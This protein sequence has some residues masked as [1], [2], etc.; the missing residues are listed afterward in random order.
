M[1]SCDGCHSKFNRQGDLIQHLQKSKNLLCAAARESLQ[2][3]MRPVQGGRPLSPTR[4]PRKHR[5]TTPLAAGPSSEGAEERL[6][7][8]QFEGDFFGNDYGDADFPF[9]EDGVP[10]GSDE[11]DVED[12][13]VYWDSEGEDG[14]FSTANQPQ[15]SGRSTTGVRDHQQPQD[16]RAPSVPPVAGSAEPPADSMDVDEDNR[17][18]DRRSLAPGGVSVEGH[19]RLKKAPVYVSKFGGQAGKPLTASSI[20]GVAGYSGY[21]EQTGGHENIWAPFKS[22]LEWEIAQWAKLRGPGATAF[23]ELLEIEGVSQLSLSSRSLSEISL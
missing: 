6:E 10:V 21:A 3:K 23:T 5:M 18:N 15:I 13:S 8:A 19:N 9:P 14:D 7:T 22:K 16:P 11:V 2:Q 4:N 20:H 1:F 12:K 17:P